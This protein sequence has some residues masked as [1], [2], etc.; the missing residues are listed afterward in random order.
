MAVTAGLCRVRLLIKNDFTRVLKYSTLVNSVSLNSVSRKKHTFIYGI[1]QLCAVSSVLRKNVV[2]GWESKRVGWWL[3]PL[4]PARDRKHSLQSVVL[5][6]SFSES[7][8]KCVGLFIAN[9]YITN[10]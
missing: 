10:N 2:R 5:L 1:V 6:L 7:E 8:V 4:L 3:N 9:Y